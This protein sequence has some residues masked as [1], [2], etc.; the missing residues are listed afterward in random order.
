MEKRKDKRVCLERV[1]RHWKSSN[2]TMRFLG[3]QGFWYAIQVFAAW[4]QSITHWF[5]CLPVSI[6]KCWLWNVAWMWS[7]AM[8]EKKRK[9]ILQCCVGSTLFW[10]RLKSFHTI[11]ESAGQLIQNNQSQ[12][13]RSRTEHR[14]QTCSSK[15]SSNPRNRWSHRK[16][17]T[18]ANCYSHFSRGDKAEAFT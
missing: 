2:E 17:Q 6:T 7:R 16:I 12:Q 10:H 13:G 9:K 5:G 8:I 4:V 14:L 18:E 11:Y 15:G 3:P 1:M